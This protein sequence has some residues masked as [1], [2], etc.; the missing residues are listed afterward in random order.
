MIPDKINKVKLASLMVMVLIGI[1]IVAGCSNSF[2]DDDGRERMEDRVTDDGRLPLEDADLAAHQPGRLLLQGE[3]DDEVKEMLD[4]LEAEVVAD[5]KD[6][7]LNA[8]KIRVPEGTALTESIA[9]L[10]GLAAV[11]HAE[12]NYEQKVIREDFTE[13]KPDL[14]P[15]I[16]GLAGI[17]AHYAD[18]LWGLAAVNAPQAWEISRG[19]DVV[20][21]V[22]DT[23][24]QAGHPDL[25][26]RVLPGFNVYDNDSSTEDR[27]GHGTHV[28]GTIAAGAGGGVVGVAK[29]AG[30]LP[31]KVFHEEGYPP[32]V[33]EVARGIAWL[34]QWARE[35]DSRVVANMSLGSG[36]YSSIFKDALDA[37]LAEDV[38]LVASMG[39][40]AMRDSQYPARFDGVIAA[41]AI[42]GNFEQAD[43]TTSGDWMSVTAPG[44][45]ILST[46]P[47]NWYGV[48]GG[49]SMSSAYV[50]GVAALLLAEY[51]DLTPGEVK[52]ILE[53]TADNRWADNFTPDFGHGLVDAEAALTYA[54]EP[55]DRYSLEVEALQFDIS[56]QSY[57]PS[58][59][60]RVALY[61]EDGSFIKD[62]KTNQ[63]GRFV[64]HNLKA[65]DYQVR[66][67][68]SFADEGQR[69]ELNDDG[70][71]EGYGYAY[72]Y[73]SRDFSLTADR[74]LEIELET[75]E[76]EDVSAVTDGEEEASEER[77][78]FIS[79]LAGVEVLDG[80]DKTVFQNLQYPDYALDLDKL[81]PDEDEDREKL[82]DY[83]KAHPGSILLSPGFYSLRA[84]FEPMTVGI[85]GVT[86]LEEEV[87]I[88]LASGES[89]AVNFDFSEKSLPENTGV[90]ALGINFRDS[91][92][93]IIEDEPGTAEITFKQDDRIIEV[94][95]F[96]DGT[97]ELIIE[98]EVSVLLARAGEYDVSIQGGISYDA[99]EPEEYRKVGYAED[100]IVIEAEEINRKTINLWLE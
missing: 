17:D 73:Q 55:A 35:N 51:P 6:L 78:N 32:Y 95:K 98:P 28:A 2:L 100:S 8:Y 23:G 25:R 21:A 53:N 10:E 99:D 44:T 77:L 24:V 18:H 74:E 96:E 58:Y 88:E 40:S 62:G 39:N 4:S 92:G 52:E 5:L 71:L 97:E 34:A 94:I 60:S 3:I 41:G 29:E 81:D 42:D 87:E 61:N 76:L 90:L 31:I 59:K 56:S 72:L 15:E 30:I 1:I 63:A 49:T 86:R 46:I 36:Y 83:L 11:E 27:E 80:Q 22:I 19:E 89:T 26:G 84:E 79:W 91:W 85:P 48:L 33:F 67:H 57:L 12:P 7:G 68:H 50:A 47:G 69:V 14:Q 38:V 64:F 70:S 45:E 54:Y 37:A 66:V 16:Q 9:K 93:T 75:A 65:G 43:F 20:V 13:L 82:R